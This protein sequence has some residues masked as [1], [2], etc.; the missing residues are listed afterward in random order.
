MEPTINRE[1]DNEHKPELSM[2]EGVETTLDHSTGG[3]DPSI[4][5]PREEPQQ[6]L[7]AEKPPVEGTENQQTPPEPAPEGEA[8]EPPAFTPD[9]KFKVRDQ[10]M[11][12]DEWVKPLVKDEETFKKMQDLYT[13]GHGLEIAKQERDQY[14]QQFTDLEASVNH[15]ASISQKYYQDPTNPQ[16]AANV[17]R[18]FIT[19]LGLPPQMF[20]QYAIDEVKYRNLPADQKAQIDMQRQ[21]EIERAQLQ[22]QNQ[23]LQEQ[24]RSTESQHYEQM[25]D[26]KLAD[27]NIGSVIS[28][29][30]T[31]VGKP[32]AFREL[33]IQRGIFHSQMNNQIITPDQAVN[34]VVQMLGI[35]PGGTQTQT[36]GHAGT[37]QNLSQQQNV[38]PAPQQT[39]QSQKPVLPNI[40]GQGTAS[41]VKRTYN[42]LEQ[43]R[44]RREELQ[45]QGL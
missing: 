9:Y 43:I 15:V 13:R 36:G 20:L 7:G 30:E 10:E 37:Q 12:M 26:Y 21:A 38:Q 25:L 22:M 45:A 44:K 42:S 41:P 3:D 6:T 11:E 35:T 31:R 32:G 40:S 8:G 34:E 17:A 1:H 28:E 23:Q 14:K 24:Q 5:I 27:P 4:N 29:Y 18:E 39:A 2:G 16:H 33:V 19:A